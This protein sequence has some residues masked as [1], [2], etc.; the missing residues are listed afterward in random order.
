MAAAQ[1]QTGYELNLEEYW[2][3]LLRRRWWIMMSAL[4]M[5]VFSWLF[6]WVKQPPPLY[7]SSAQVKIEQSSNLA[8]ALLRGEGFTQTNTMSTN[9]ALVRSYA[10][11]ERV[12]KRLGLIP[13]GLTSAE[14]RAND[15]YMDQVLS[16]RDS[17]EAEQEGD[18]G[19]IT[20]SAVSSSPEFARDL[21]QA[22][23]DEFQ[24]FNIQEKNK[25]VFE[26]KKFIEDQIVVVGDRLNKAEEAVREYRSSHNMVM[27]GKDSDVMAKVGADLEQEYRQEVA[28]LNDL[29]FTLGQL[30]ERVTHGG[31]DY[32]A[33]SVSGQVSAYFDQLNKRLVELA[34]KRTEL[35]TNFT[36]Q[37][38]EMLELR[39]QAND[40][41]VSMVDELQKQVQ[42]SQQRLQSTQQAIEENMRRYQGLPEEALQLQ[43]LERSVRLNE[44]LYD[45]LEKKHQEVLIREA[46]KEQDVTLVRPALLSNARINPVRTG[47][48]AIA[49][50]IL[51]LVLGLIIALILES[52]DT[53][54]GTIEEV[55]NFLEVPVVGFVPHLSHEEAIHLFSGVEGLAVSGHQLERQIRLVTH[56][57]PPSTIAEAYRSLRTNLMFSQAAE[58]RVLIVT[59]STVKEGK[60][61]IAA[62]LAVVVAQQGARVL[63]IDADM[64]KPMLHHTFGLER[65][66]GLCECLLGQESWQHA[67]KRFSDVMLG[68]MGVDQA[69]M[70]PGLDQLDILTC[71]TVSANPPDLLSTPQMKTLLAEVRQEYDLVVIDMPPM[72]H[73]T[74]ATVLAA[75][76]DGVLLV[77]HIGAVVRGALKRVKSTIESVGGHVVGVVLNG[78]RGD[79][80]PDYATYKMDRYYAYSYGEHSTERGDW[81]ERLLGKAGHQWRHV[82]RRITGRRRRGGGNA[83]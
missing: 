51:G 77:Y 17:V 72:L 61:T 20:I 15:E 76:A 23:A 48:T 69:L 53:S 27:V 5:C 49:G 38:P 32:Q 65:D 10:M 44:D 80:S 1:S 79:V 47:Q 26:A 43:R 41:L 19:I 3:I 83:A 8:D 52:I 73:A 33:V 21:A 24:A 30:K 6:T 18:S 39:D 70:T 16:L 31:W 54:V 13:K 82:Y 75:S 46:E 28:R 12:S 9:L 66:P 2:Q 36:D 60:S 67:V 45:L 25:R 50:L 64:R 68:N 7:S 56:F 71:G 29:R 35:S 57:S 42:L 62:N 58:R 14:I 37:H 11:M 78:V 81:F 74:D 22:V 59:S 4:L 55:E 40:I 63:L 34:L